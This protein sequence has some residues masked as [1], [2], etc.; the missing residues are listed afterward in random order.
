MS[1]RAIEITPH[2]LG[3]IG[4]LLLGAGCIFPSPPPEDLVHVRTY[5]LPADSDKYLYVAQVEGGIVQ[6]ET[7][8]VGWS[9]GTQLA[10]ISA[11]GR[12]QQADIL[13]WTNAVRYGVLIRDKR[14]NWRIWWFDKRATMGFA[15]D[16]KDGRSRCDFD[17]SKAA[18][19]EGLSQDVLSFLGLR[20]GLQRPNW[21]LI[22]PEEHLT[23]K[24]GRMPRLVL[25]RCREE[26]LSLLGS[27][28]GLATAGL[29]PES[30]IKCAIV[31]DGLE[32]QIRNYPR[33]TAPEGAGL[34]KVF[35]SFLE[36]DRAA[37]VGD[38]GA[39]RADIQEMR[40]GLLLL[41]GGEE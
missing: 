7:Y 5:P 8:G 28:E 18:S 25:R 15:P 1:R 6:L 33:W 12:S 39:I 38:P 29:F 37:S 23:W 40:E 14:R 31:L 34:E 10:G 19:V 22:G 35:R 21:T 24:D 27:A 13:K 11:E 2:F 26:Y 17:L 9:A 4:S 36:V 20:Y 32:E 30:A 3:V 41:A 16:S